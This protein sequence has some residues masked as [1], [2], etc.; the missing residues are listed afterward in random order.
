MMKYIIRRSLLAILITGLLTVQVNAE[1]LAVA[2]S[3]AFNDGSNIR[4]A[5]KNECNLGPKLSTFIHAYAG[6][7]FTVVSQVGA[8]ANSKRLNISIVDASG[9][10]GGAWSGSKSVTIEGSLSQNGQILGTFTARRHSGGGAFGGYKGTCSILGRCV[11]ALG[12][13][14]AAWATNPATDSRLGDL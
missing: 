14:L 4:D 3:I 11:K 6:K 9:N 10:A 7:H 12:K 8:P 2:D 5:I 13:D 1:T